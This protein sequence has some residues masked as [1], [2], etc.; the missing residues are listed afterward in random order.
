MYNLDYL[1]TDLGCKSA[2]VKRDPK[3]IDQFILMKAIV[4]ASLPKLLFTDIKIF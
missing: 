3:L 1:A 4:D 2:K